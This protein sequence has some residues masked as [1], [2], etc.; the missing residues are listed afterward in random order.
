LTTLDPTTILASLGI[1]QHR[2]VTPIAGGWDTSLWRVDDG[3]QMYALRVFRRE[4]APVC[5]R[6]A[7]VMRALADLG[8]PVPRVHAENSETPAL[9]LGWCPGVP[10]LHE[11]KARPWRIWHLG[12]VMGQMHA[13]IH[14]VQVSDALAK[15]LPSVPEI[16]H[17]RDRLSILHRDYHPLNVMTDGHA[18][19]GVLD[20]ANVAVGDPRVDLARTVTLLRLAPLPPGTPQVLALALRGIL[21]LAWRRGYRQAQP[22]DPFKGMDPFYVWAGDMMERDLQPKLGRPGVWLKES[23]LLH[24]RRWT[25]SRRQRRITPPDA[26]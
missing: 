9:L 25:M 5:R 8:L 23:D 20:W 14:A 17:T 6:E 12:V 11:I 2:G 19:S 22:T 24:I 26:A 18:V 13:R 1:S 4:Q 10:I 16:D 21:E 3:R 15:A 7:L